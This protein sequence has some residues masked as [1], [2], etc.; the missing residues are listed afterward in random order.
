MGEE[1]RMNVMECGV[2]VMG[3]ECRMNVMECGVGVME[4]GMGDWGGMW[5]GCDGGGV[6]Q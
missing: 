5:G 1:C 2:G 6:C 4:C 3:E